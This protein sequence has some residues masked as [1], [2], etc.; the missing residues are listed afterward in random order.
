MPNKAEVTAQLVDAAAAAAE[1]RLTAKEVVTAVVAGG[2]SGGERY[3]D[4]E[5]LAYSALELIVHKAYTA[6]LDERTKIIR[7]KIFW[8][9]LCILFGR[10]KVRHVA[11]AVDLP[12]VIEAALGYVAGGV[13]P[14]GVH[15]VK[16][17]PEAGGLGAP[18]NAIAQVCPRCADLGR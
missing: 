16:P 18:V 2:T 4:H 6:Q 7:F 8:N 11:P 9:I 14:V 17:P 12:N 5:D 15:G 13:Q 3:Y 10:H 1:K